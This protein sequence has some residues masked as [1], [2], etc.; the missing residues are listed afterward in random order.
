MQNKPAYAIESVDH[1]L[2]LALLLQ[3]EG[4]I[5]VSDAAARLGIARSTAHRLLAMLVYRDFAEQDEDKRYHP[6][7]VLR[8]AAATP[9][10]VSTLRA[11]ALPHLRNLMEQVGESVNLQV[12]VGDQIRFVVSVECHQVLRVGNR[13]GRV[14]P[15]HLVSG[16]KALLATLDDADL[17]ALYGAGTPPELDLAGLRRELRL[18]RQRGF[19]LNDQ[20]TENGVTAIGRVVR[21]ARG[22]PL[23]AVCL[24]MPTARFSRDRLPD[25][26]AALTTT[27]SRIEHDL[28]SPTVS[29]DSRKE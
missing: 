24:A 7:P 3:Q 13:E 11:V 12:R 25:W 19:A 26:I 2:H 6:G 27:A 8:V 28:T 17:A 1:A 14:L 21:N 5:R 23:A 29:T 9:E 20:K 18:V 15:A 4:P 16:G 22:V 10:P